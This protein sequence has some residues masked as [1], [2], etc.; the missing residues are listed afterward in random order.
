MGSD[1]SLKC[2]NKRVVKFQSTLPV[3]GATE[4]AVKEAKTCLISIHAPRVG[5]DYNT[6]W[7]GRTRGNHFNPRSPCGER[8]N[9]DSSMY[10]AIVIS[11]HAPRVGSDLYS[12][13]NFAYIVDFNPRSP[14]GERRLG[15]VTVFDFGYFNPRSPCGERHYTYRKKTS[16]IVDFNPRSP[17]GE[18]QQNSPKVRY[19]RSC[20]Y[21]EF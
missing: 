19:I 8:H 10:T 4:D 13:K 16:Y 14:C 20:I 3:W 11:I 5:S 7:Q 12:R 1:V 18:R 6:M 2:Y 21:S 15:V 9:G 17:C